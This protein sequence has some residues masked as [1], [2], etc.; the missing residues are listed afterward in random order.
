LRLVLV[1]S[2]SYDEYVAMFDLGPGDLAGSVL[3]CCAGAADFVA[4]VRQQGGHAVAVDPV[5]ARPPGELA[6]AARADLDRG[7]AIADGFPD[8]FVWDWYGTRERRDTL[9]RSAVARFLADR[10]TSPAA[11][12]AGALPRLPFTDA[13][14]DLLVCSHL[15]FTWADTLGLAWHRAALVEMTRVARQVRV[16]PTVLQGAGE[17]VPFWDELM[18]DLGEAGVTSAVRQVGYRLQRTGDRMLVVSRR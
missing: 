1:T 15:L 3:D 5:Y 2:R 8:R 7:A 18:A 12:V 11:Y 13:A 16:F 9:R 6:D 17:P 4:R 14:F 10:S